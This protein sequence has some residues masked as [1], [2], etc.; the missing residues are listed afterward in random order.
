ML[1]KALTRLEAAAQRC[2][3]RACRRGWFDK[4][5]APSPAFVALTRIVQDQLGELRRMVET[6][7]GTAPQT[8]RE[9]LHR[10]EILDDP[11]AGDEDRGSG[12]LRGDVS[13]LILSAQRP[14]FRDAPRVS[15]Q[16]QIADGRLA[17]LPPAQT[18]DDDLAE[19]DAAHERARRAAETTGADEPTEL[20]TPHSEAP[21]ANPAAWAEAWRQN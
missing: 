7:A 15:L 13:A 10:V 9:I 20:D 11:S 21:A 2:E 3:E 4:T 5:S 17:E 12:D 18:L 19:R 16:A 14:D 8:P 6:L 1:G